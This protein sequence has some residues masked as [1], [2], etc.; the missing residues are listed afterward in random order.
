M[1]SVSPLRPP[2]AKLIRPFFLS[3]SSL[4]TRLGDIL[5][6]AKA[7]EE[8]MEGGNGRRSSIN[9]FRNLGSLICIHDVLTA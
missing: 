8:R 9:R 3:F 5:G 4:V 7:L 1:P 6:S 2:F